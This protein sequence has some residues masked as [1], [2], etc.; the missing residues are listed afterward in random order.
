VYAPP[1][2][3]PAQ[4][5]F[6][7]PQPVPVPDPAAVPYYGAPLKI[8]PSKST[9]PTKLPPDPHKIGRGSN[10]TDRRVAAMSQE[11]IELE[12]AKKLKDW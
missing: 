3:A 9:I 2:P 12:R 11:E 1:V 5:M 7:P 4:P 8:E 6:V 10:N